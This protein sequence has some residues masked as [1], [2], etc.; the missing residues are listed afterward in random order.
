[1]SDFCV[2]C[3]EKPTAKTKEHVIP[4]WL[5]ELTGDPHRK[6]TFGPIWTG[7][8]FE[9]RQFPFRHFAFP[10]CE[11]CNQR[12]S[13]LEDSAKRV[14]IDILAEKAL[15]ATDICVLLSW[16]DKV[17]IGLWL[18]Y[19]YI[20]KNACDISPNFY[21]NSRIDGSDRMVLIYKSDYSYR[22]T[23]FDG[24]Q[25]P[26]FQYIPSCFCLSVNN[27]HFFSVAT[28]LLLS[29]RL[30]LPYATGASYTNTP[31]FKFEVV[32]GRERMIY[33]PMRI[34]YE[35]ACSQIFQ[36]MFTMVKERASE[37]AEYETDY[38][39]SMMMDH[40]RGIGKVLYYNGRRL[41]E[42]PSAESTCW[43]P[44][45]TW[46]EEELRRI[47]VKQVLAF[48]LHLLRYGPL[49]D[50]KVD[51]ST[52]TPEKR[53]LIRRDLYFASQISKMLLEKMGQLMNSRR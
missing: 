4:Q 3:G 2:F 13:K 7:K 22:R 50:R 15:S 6:G 24:A 27:F 39:K 30:G 37:W 43:I 34:R 41:N 19:L 45:K 9:F 26:A 35:R 14:L 5:I 20:Q 23:T 1:M 17:R 36:P 48:Q 46:R 28:H 42:F 51:Y 31:L 11:Q 44:P 40:K 53:R 29:K 52:V 21:I 8:G 49:E 25:F 18:A 38:V 12:M 10:A 32:E 16:L 33:P 47:L